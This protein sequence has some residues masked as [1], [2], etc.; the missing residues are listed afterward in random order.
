ML[1][2]PRLGLKYLGVRRVESKGPDPGGGGLSLGRFLDELQDGVEGTDPPE[3]GITEIA[4]PHCSGPGGRGAGA[5]LGCGAWD[6]SNAH[7]F[8]LPSALK[9]FSS[10]FQTRFQQLLLQE[11]FQAPPGETLLLFWAAQPA[12]G[13][14]QTTPG[15]GSLTLIRLLKIGSSCSRQNLGLKPLGATGVPGTPGQKQMA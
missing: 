15:R 4:S 3:V 13:R 12:S 2:F 1:L 9:T 14:F 11:A 7:C 6:A 10:L 5:G 8:P